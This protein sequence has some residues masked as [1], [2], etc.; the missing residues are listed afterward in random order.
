MKNTISRIGQSIKLPGLS[1]LMAFTITG[2]IIAVSDEKV[3]NKISSPIEFLKSAGVSVGNAY[4]ALF[5]GS[6]YDNR[7][8]KSNFFEG[9][10]PFFETLVTATPLILTGLSV[11]LA[12]KSG[13][14]NIGAQGQFIFGAIGAS[15]VGFRF[16]LPVGIHILA[17]ALAGIV[18]A[19]IW[20]GLVGFLKAKTGAHEVI[21]TIML[22]YIAAFFIL[23]LLKTKAF[24]RPGRIDPIAP[25]VADSAK[26]PLLA[27]ENFRIHAGIFIALAAA[28]F[29]WW[30]LTKTTIGYKFRAVGANS[31]AAKTAGISVPFVI[32]STM[33]ICGALAGLGGAVHVL[34]SE[35]A[36]NTDVAGSFGFDA[37][38]VALLGR[39]QPLGTVFAALLFG[40]LHTGGRMMQSNTG[41]PL[42]IVVVTQGLIV[43]FIAAPMFVR[44][45]FKLKKLNASTS[46]TSKGW[47]G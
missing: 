37:I 5:Q 14:F 19:A 20:G 16:E 10:Y 23:W 41:V 2:I 24:L 6:I 9:F 11:A 12:F 26:L 17:A 36:L 1:F 35:H 25:E 8:A 31:Q 43:L 44:Y 3:M 45:I 33:M 40:A 18:L 4:L 30:L 21:L 15:Y 39:A 27:G 47:N 22:N 28:F 7:L 42:D 38:T 46:L 13:L 32:T 29:V 34:G